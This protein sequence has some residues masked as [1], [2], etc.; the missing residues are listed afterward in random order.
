M[1]IFS[2]SNLYGHMHIHVQN[3]YVYIYIHA[4]IYTLYV[5]TYVQPR[6]YWLSKMNC[7]VPLAFTCEALSLL[8]IRIRTGRRH[9]IRSHCAHI[10][11]W[12]AFKDGLKP[13]YGRRRSHGTGAVHSRGHPTVYDGKYTAL[14]TSFG[15]AKWCEQNCRSEAAGPKPLLVRIRKLR[16]SG[17]GLGAFSWPV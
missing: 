12:H 15:D 16:S 11:P 1:C 3:L 17:L 6:V 7:R 8:T 5:P 9:Q 4:Y 14:D 10:G 2:N 13:M